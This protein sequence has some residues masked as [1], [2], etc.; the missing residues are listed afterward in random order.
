MDLS[1][2]GIDPL[3]GH[4]LG[5]VTVFVILLT[6]VISGPLFPFVDFTHTTAASQAAGPDTATVELIELPEDE[7]RIA[8]GRFGA[9]TYLYSSP[10]TV[11]IDNVSGSPMLV[12]ELTVPELGR[13]VVTV[14]F[15]SDRY[16]GQ[17]LTLELGRSSIDSAL[18]Q[19]SEYDG[20]VRLRLR[21]GSRTRTIHSQNVTIVVEAVN[22]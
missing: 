16:D 17:R 21:T 4:L 11:R 20:V 19:K 7:F 3:S 8:P 18:L 10:A 2:D 6:V 13:T 12:Y 5:R 15:L 22:G 9:G 14:V 1:S